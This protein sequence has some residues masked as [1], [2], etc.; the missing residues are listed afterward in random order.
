M[1]K[2]GI[3]MLLILL[4][5]AAVLAGAVFLFISQP[6]FGRAPRGERLK[7]V[8]AS[9]HYHNGHFENE[10]PTVT[11]TSDK[12]TLRALWD[13]LFKKTENLRPSEPV[14]SVHTDLSALPPQDLI[15]W[16]GHSAYLVQLGG[17]KILVDPAL[18]AGS[19]VPFFNKPYPGTDVYKPADIPAVDYLFISHDHWDHLDYQTVTA[20]KDRIGK[21][22]VPLGVGEYFEYWGF[23]P[24]KIV[25]LDWYEQADVDGLQV[26]A[27][28][29]RH[30]SGRGLAP[31]RMLWASFVVQSPTGRKVYIGGDS[32]YGP[33]FAK[34]GAAHPQLDL[35]ILENGQYDKD[36]SQIHTLPEQLPQVMKDLHAQK[37]VT[38]HHSKFTLANH[39]WDEPLKV[40]KEAAAAAGQEL[41]VLTI[42]QPAL[43]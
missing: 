9:A 37:A 11:M 7:R 38:V 8:Q 1:K 20:L 33:H 2:T 3:K 28:P 12:G 22:V 5:A 25:E 16:F 18:V 42:G 29:A 36:W 23:P 34:I 13:F 32:G 24:E 43:F 40:E 14:P 21:V 10:I 31:N 41:L 17:K 4:I 26:Q 27:F 30:F 15:V 19:P 39:A 35:A 6:S